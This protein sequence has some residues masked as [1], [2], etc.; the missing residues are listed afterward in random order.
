[1]K[2]AHQSLVQDRLNVNLIHQ[3]K[4]C[5]EEAIWWNKIDEMILVQKA[6]IKWL[7]AGDGNNVFFHATVKER[8]RRVGIR[9]LVND[10]NQTLTTQEYVEQEVLDFYSNLVGTAADRIEGVDITALRQGNHLSRNERISL[11]R[12][13]TEQEIWTAL[14][15]IGDNKALGIDG[16]NACFFKAT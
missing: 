13:I 1:M 10:Q 16:F 6:K 3:V 15:E 11:L 9:K 14:T 7:R 4:S 2:G 8:N 5:T 12:P